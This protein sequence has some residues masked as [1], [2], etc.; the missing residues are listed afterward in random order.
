MFSETSL[1]G[2]SPSGGDGS[3]L[4]TLPLAEVI[5]TIPP[6]F[7]MREIVLDT[8][9]TGLDPSGGDRVVE[10]GCVELVNHIPSGRKFHR[11]VNPERRMSVDAAKVHGLDD[12]FLKD[13]PTFAAVA[14]ELADFLGDAVLIAHNAEFD[15]AFLNAE[16]GRA[17]HAPIG[18]NRV[19][20]TL[21][22]ARRKHPLGP[23]SLDALMSRYSIDSSKRVLHG[24]LLDAELLSEVYVELIGGR[25]PS[26]L[27]GDEE[28][29]PTIALPPRPATIAIRPFP[30]VFEIP[31]I[32]LAA[33]RAAVERLGQNAIWQRYLRPAPEM[34]QLA[35]AG[36]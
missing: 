20:D 29:V 19:V 2:T 32:D 10:I 11:Y 3:L 34:P 12:A 23:N 33:H 30:R 13:K 5:R 25:Q 27:L 15:L 9:T 17:G 8:E 14:R 31:D 4:F 36:G 6:G 1:L 26:L 16:F 18:G 28:S 22:L 21:M 7:A 35:V 24:A